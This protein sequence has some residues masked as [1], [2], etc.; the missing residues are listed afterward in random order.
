MSQFTPLP[1]SRAEAKNAGL[2]SEAPAWRNTAIAAAILTAAAIALP[3]ALPQTTPSPLT[4]P[5]PVSAPM[6]PASPLAV[7]AHLNPPAQVAP[8]PMRAAVQ[9]APMRLAALPAP[10][11]APAAQP[12]ACVLAARTAP[13]AMG[14]GTV[15]SFEDRV[16]SLARIPRAE[17][18][19]GGHID[20]S[21]IDNQRVVVRMSD[22]LAE[23][24]LTPRTMPVNLGDRV[25]IQGIYRNAQLPC[26][27]VPP[28]ITAD[29]G[30]APVSETVTPTKPPQP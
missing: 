23:I 7:P 15:V 13:A 19:I 24:F 21:F 4:S 18:D 16:T 8:V 2:W 25:T 3:I 14:S 6:N 17:A 12:G 27:Y 28:L 26:N 20:P 5:A 1:Q 10:Q 30:P 11:A 9:P 22:G 29:M